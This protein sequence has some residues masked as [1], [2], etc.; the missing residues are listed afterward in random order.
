[1]MRLAS[2]PSEEKGFVQLSTEG[3]A[4]AT[5]DF[6]RLGAVPDDEENY[7]GSYSISLEKPYRSGIVRDF[8]RR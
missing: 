5:S 8:R 7:E 4:S 3:L 1:M 2:A 6:L